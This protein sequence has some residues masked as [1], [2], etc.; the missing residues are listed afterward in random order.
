MDR[1]GVRNIT[2]ADRIAVRV[3]EV[4]GQ[5]EAGNGTAGVAVSAV[6]TAPVPVDAMP[7]LGFRAYIPA[8]GGFAYFEGTKRDDLPEVGG[9][10]S[11]VASEGT[12]AREVLGGDDVGE[13]TGG[14]GGTYDDGVLG[15]VPWP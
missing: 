2:R 6:V 3:A 15:F 14:R 10:G 1:L 12:G 7:S 9:P 4:G 8:E 13:V 5:F 11:L